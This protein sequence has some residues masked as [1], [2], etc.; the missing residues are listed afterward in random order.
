METYKSVCH[1]FVGDAELRGDQRVRNKLLDLL[2]EMKV[3]WTP[4]VQ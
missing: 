2:E 1:L 4:D 3:G